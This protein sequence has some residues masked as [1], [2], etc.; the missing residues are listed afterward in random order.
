MSDNYRIAVLAVLVLVAIAAAVQVN[1]P[2]TTSLYGDQAAHLIAAQSLVFD[3]DLRY[4]LTDLDRFRDTTPF[5]AGPRGMFLKLGRDGDFYYAKPFTYAFAASLLWR[6][7]GIDSFRLLNALCLIIIAGTFV[8]SVRTLLSAWM[9]V[10]VALGLFW[11]SP[12]LAW[13]GV[14][15]PDLF[16]GALLALGGY[17]MLRPGRTVT[18]SAVSGV[19]LGLCLYEKP[20]FILPVVALFIC[21]YWDNRPRSA[22][23]AAAVAVL[24][25]WLI[26]TSVQLF[27]D[28]HLLAYQGVRF[29]VSGDH[30]FPLEAGWVAPTFGGT[31]H[32]FNLHNLVDAVLTNARLLPEKLSDFLVGRQTGIVVYFPTMAALIVVTVAVGWRSWRAMLLLAAFFGVL[33]IYWVAFPRNGYG[34]SQSFGSRYLMQLLPVAWLSACFVTSVRG[35]AGALLANG[36]AAVGV[37]LACVLHFDVL[38]RGIAFAAAPRLFLESPRAQLFPLERTLVPVVAPIL[39]ASFS[40]RYG[41]N[42]LYRLGGDPLACYGVGLDGGSILVSLSGNRRTEVALGFEVSAPV[43]LT[44][45]SH[46]SEVSRI[47]AVPGSTNTTRIFVRPD[48]SYRDLTAGPYNFAEVTIEPSVAGMRTDR[49]ADVFVV[50]QPYVA[51]DQKRELAMLPPGR[52]DERKFDEAGVR[53]T[54]CWSWSQSDG[55]W[56][57][58]K[59]AGL[60]T[61]I[62]VAQD[63]EMM[64]EMEFVPHIPPAAEQGV[65]IFANG[66]R[67]FSGTYA[68]GD[69]TLQSARFSVPKDVVDASG[70]LNLLLQIAHPARIFGSHGDPRFLGVKLNSVSFS[71]VPSVRLAVPLYFDAKSNGV[72]MLGGG[73]SRPE[74]WGVWS[75]SDKASLHIP[76]PENATGTLKLEFDVRAY[77]PEAHPTQT[78]DVWVN[79]RMYDRWIFDTAHPAGLRTI[80]I[81]DVSNVPDIDIDF[82]VDSPVSPKDL[83]MSDDT[84]KLGVGLVRMVPIAVSV[85]R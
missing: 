58:G 5:S 18:T 12:Y 66:S 76:R 31:T 28:G 29:Y 42:T 65:A 51:G 32:I 70:V 1:S 13:V 37:V 56:T 24:V 59:V 45:S 4:S 60:T 7:A 20:T 83:G 72:A 19:L 47:R 9:V 52:V 41:S 35:R 62:S 75:S 36:F 57:S 50:V 81:D 78:V 3:H 46:G 53:R 74:R 64:G 22:A 82:V 80:Q 44:L 15:H 38:K 63:Q 34:G 85:E 61:K 73:W 16:I 71:S 17:L 21:G 26:P 77:L 33:T 48:L 2:P 79:R 30:G 27:Q 23:L 14:M 69:E 40:Q 54:L 39:P 6:L 43:D 25:G 67:V 84:R 10:P 49:Y 68:S 55:R 8:L 11:F